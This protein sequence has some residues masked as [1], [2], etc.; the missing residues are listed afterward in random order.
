MASQTAEYSR[1]GQE[2]LRYFS[3]RPNLKDLFKVELHMRLLYGH[4]G[5]LAKRSERKVKFE[6]VLTILSQRAE[7]DDINS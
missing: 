1:R 3:P 2:I 5:A 4:N 7:S 6:Q